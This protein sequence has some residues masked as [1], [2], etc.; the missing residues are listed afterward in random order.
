MHGQADAYISQAFGELFA[1]SPARAIKEG[2]KPLPA[3]GSS[4]GWGLRRPGEF[5]TGDIPQGLWWGQRLSWLRLGQKERN[6]KSKCDCCLLPAMVATPSSPP[7]R[8]PARTL[9][10]GPTPSVLPCV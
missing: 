3:V 2:D 6:T 10:E 9:S 4:G 5:C 1:G 8:P 7:S